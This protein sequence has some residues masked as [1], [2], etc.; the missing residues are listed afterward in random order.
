MATKRVVIL[1]KTLVAKQ[2]WAFHLIQ[3]QFLY[4]RFGKPTPEQVHIDRWTW[5]LHGDGKVTVLRSWGKQ[6][7]QDW[8][9]PNAQLAARHVESFTG[10]WILPWI[11]QEKWNSG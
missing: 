1:R 6:Y 8:M 5:S 4:D 2:V 9:F 7:A 10:V 11:W 3:R